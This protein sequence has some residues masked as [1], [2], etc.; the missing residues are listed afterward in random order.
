M[1]IPRQED[2]ALL[3]MGELAKHYR[4]GVLSLSSIATIHGVSPLFLKKIARLLRGAGL[5]E[6]KEGQNGGY[7]IAR[8]PKEIT[9]W[10]IL[11][12]VAGPD[13]ERPN[14]LKNTSICPLVSNCLPQQINKRIYDT[15]EEGF[16]KMR[17]SDLL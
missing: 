17:V 9:V 2:V 3:L 8:H 16:T 11:Q 10:Q 5:I 6:S 12:A 1:K 13:P 7:T 4:M 15:L 14:Q